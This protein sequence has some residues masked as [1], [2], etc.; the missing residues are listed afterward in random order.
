MKD[1]N[2]QSEFI[3]PE[4]YAEKAIAHAINEGVAAVDPVRHLD[5][6]HEHMHVVRHGP[7]QNFL[8]YREE[9]ETGF[10]GESGSVRAGVGN[11]GLMHFMP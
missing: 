1:E 10:V 3:K 4:S 6:E 5:Q 8:G 11:C 9:Y 2:N 7:Q